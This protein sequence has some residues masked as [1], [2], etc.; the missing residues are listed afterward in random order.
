MSDSLFIC[1]HTKITTQR[2]FSAKSTLD[3]LRSD[4]TLGKKQPVN[5]ANK[6]KQK[7]GS[8]VIFHRIDKASLCVPGSWLWARHNSAQSSPDTATA[9]QIPITNRL[10]SKEQ[11][12]KQGACMAAQYPGADGTLS[13]FVLCVRRTTKGRHVSNIIWRTSVGWAA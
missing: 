5:I 4:H 7:Y 10:A 6:Q 1:M 3:L 12:S 11:A 13:I 9:P 8:A 2:G